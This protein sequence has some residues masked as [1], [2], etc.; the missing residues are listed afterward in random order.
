MRNLTAIL[1][2]TVATF[3]EK[4][5]IFTFSDKILRNPKQRMVKMK[6][7]LM[8]F[9]TVLIVT[10]CQT[11]KDA[12]NLATIGVDFKFEKRHGCSPTSPQFNI[13]KI[14]SGTGFL[15]FAMTDLDF[16]TADHGGGTVKYS[17]S[18]KISE[19]ALDSYRGP[20]PPVEHRYEMVVEALNAKK[21]L[22]LGRG[23]STRTFCCR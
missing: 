3:A 16:T 4:R 10:G 18:G 11:T 22:V 19:G 20:C 7:L 14:P 6:H 8:I 21:D 23:K 17:G 13:S 9:A 2:L 5:N 1:C 12:S 15:R